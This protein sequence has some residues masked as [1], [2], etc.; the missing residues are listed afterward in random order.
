VNTCLSTLSLKPSGTKTV[1]NRFVRVN[2]RRG[3]TLIEVLFV[4]LIIGILLTIA[5]PYFSRARETTNRKS[6][7][8]NMRRIQVAKDSYLMDYNKPA[9][10]PASAF[11]D[12][13]L[14]GS[15]RY[16][17]N[18][19]KCPGGGTYSPNSAGEVPT[20]SYSGG[21]VHVYTDTGG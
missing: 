11:T 20:C 2:E 9:D 4:I 6:C 13:V 1:P 15:G 18:K 5:V 10:T 14:Y 16:L 8:A 12:E 7:T 21:E 3:F 17:D 19:P